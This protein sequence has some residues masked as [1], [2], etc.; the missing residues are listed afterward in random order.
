MRVRPNG[1][2]GQPWAEAEGV[3]LFLTY[4]PNLEALADLREFFKSR[5]TKPLDL[6]VAAKCFRKHLG[7]S[8][9]PPL[10]G[11]PAMTSCWRSTVSNETPP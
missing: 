9:E 4:K 3:L 1:G 6:I 10:R 7:L 11:M 2:G 5:T 8:F